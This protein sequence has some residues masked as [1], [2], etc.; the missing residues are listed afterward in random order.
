MFDRE[1]ILY[2]ADIVIRGLAVM[3]FVG[4]WHFIR[5]YNIEKWVMLAV[6]AA[7]QIYKMPGMGEEKKKWVLD[8]LAGRIRWITAEELDAFIE[9]AVLEINRFKNKLEQPVR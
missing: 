2:I 9:A 3:L 8:F 6:K 7:E 5:K 1:T 4:L